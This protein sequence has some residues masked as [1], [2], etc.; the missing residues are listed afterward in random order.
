MFDCFYYLVKVKTT[1]K[2]NI[3]YHGYFSSLFKIILMKMTSAENNNHSFKI[4]N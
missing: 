2:K 3:G 1:R 4:V